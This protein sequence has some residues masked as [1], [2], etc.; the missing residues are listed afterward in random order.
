VELAV[1]LSDPR[2]DD[3]VHHDS[4]A[5]SRQRIHQI[6]AGYEDAN[7]ADRLRHDPLLQIVADQKLGEW[8]RS[9]VPT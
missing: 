2:Q 8:I 4:L 7:G 6:V 5:L 9:R 3:R 1:Q